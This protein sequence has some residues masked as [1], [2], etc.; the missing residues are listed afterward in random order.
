[1]GSFSYDLEIT[2]TIS[3]NSLFVK[4]QAS[5]DGFVVWSDDAG[6]N[7]CY[8]TKAKYHCPWKAGGIR[9]VVDSRKQF[10]VIGWMEKAFVARVRPFSQDK[11]EEE[12]ISRSGEN[13]NSLITEE[14]ATKNSEITERKSKTRRLNPIAKVLLEGIYDEKCQLNKLN[15]MWHILRQIWTNIVDFWKSNILI[16]EDFNPLERNFDV[17]LSYLNLNSLSHR[18]SERENKGSFLWVKERY[19][20]YVYENVVFPEPSGI[21]INMM[22]FIMDNRKF[23]NCC[24]PDR[25]FEY[26]DKIIRLC[27]WEDQQR[28]KVGYLTIQESVVK[29]DSSQR[30]PGL[31]TERPG[32]VRI[33][34]E[35]GKNDIAHDGAATDGDDDPEFGGGYC[36]L[37]RSSFQWGCGSYTFL[38][39]EPVV[40][41]GIYMTSNV[42]NCEILNDDLI[43]EL[44]DIE[45]LRE[46]MPEGVTMDRN[47][48]YWITDRTPH[49]SL[50][51]KESTTRQFF[52][53]VTKDVSIW[54]EDH[55]TKNP[56]GVVPDP[57]ITRIVKGSKFDKNG[58][59]FAGEKDSS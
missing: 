57:E 55:S 8:H 53:L 49:E 32:L 35:A 18:Q 7:Y 41:G 48:L 9:Y 38:R 47:C 4:G 58:V 56:L 52:R 36:S 10:S 50:P 25:F 1:M 28:G 37:R 23:S 43:G 51:L 29:K 33:N 30:R 26:W 40:E 12:G 20:P 13:S 46:F 6:K 54:Y 5:M 3:V 16:N 59:V 14:M 22:P 21:N 39:E 31:H 27:K 45:H 15:G 11:E 2:P 24:L 19:P 34:M 42:Y 44:G 17:E